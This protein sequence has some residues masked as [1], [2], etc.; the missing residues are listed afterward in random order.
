MVKDEHGDCVT[1]PGGGDV[2]P[3][4]EGDQHSVP[5]GMVKDEHGNCVT[6]PGGV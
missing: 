3:N 2:C 5:D 1:P 4:I 6:P